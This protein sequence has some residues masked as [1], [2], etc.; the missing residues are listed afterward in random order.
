[1]SKKPAKK[2]PTKV[3]R[4]PR[5]GQPTK[6]R[7]EYC[8]ML[9]EHMAAGLS[10]ETFAAVVKVDRQ[11]IYNWL[12]DQPKFFDAKKTGVVNSQLFW[13]KMGIEG[14]VGNLKGFSSAG[15]IFNMKNRF[16]W[17]NEKEDRTQQVQPILINLPLTGETKRIEMQQTLDV[18]AN[19]DLT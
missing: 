15:W 9:I 14:T 2:K 10:F 18:D 8:D 7:E 5:A 17:Q 13:E 4:R 11:T 16:G 19:D 6:Y 3:A 12:K 1:M